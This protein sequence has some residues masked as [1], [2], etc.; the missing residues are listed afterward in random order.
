MVATPATLG[1]N[2]E[3]GVSTK[4]K[5]PG[6]GPR[7]VTATEADYRAASDWAETGVIDPSEAGVLRG[8]DA[9][10]AGRA[11]IASARVGR[12]SLDPAGRPGGAG[13][14]SACTP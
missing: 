8:E 9:A 4:Q 14:D 12:P 1:K 11:L 2:G 10:A 7:T 3:L 6:R 5:A 13:Q